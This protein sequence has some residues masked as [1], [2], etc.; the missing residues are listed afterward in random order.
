MKVNFQAE[1][2]TQAAPEKI[3]GD[4][5]LSR[6]EARVILART[7]AGHAEE[8]LAR[9]SRDKS[10]VKH[11][12]KDPKTGV[13]REVSLHDVEPRNHYYLLDRI[14]EKAFATKEQK[15]QRDAVRQAAREKEKKLTQNLKDAQNRCLRLENQKKAMREKFSAEGEFQP[16]FTPKEIA[17]LEARSAQTSDKS[18]AERLEKIV[19]DAEKNNRVERLQNLLECA[20]KQL[21]IPPPSLTKIHESIV[22]GRNDSTEHQPTIGEGREISTRNEVSETSLHARGKSTEI[23]TVKQEKTAVKEKGRT[24]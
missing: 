12:I 9:D 10:F 4:F 24:R 1:P 15:I 8:D 21:Q 16:I 13:K 22:A 3:I 18:E 2:E 20:A 5:L 11:R 19:N 6:A 17:V 7:K 23:G 14:L